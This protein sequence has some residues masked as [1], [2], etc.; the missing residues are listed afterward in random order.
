[1]ELLLSEFSDVNIYLRG[2]KLKFVLSRAESGAG[3][4]FCLF[5]LILGRNC[6]AQRGKV[7]FWPHNF[8]L[9]IFSQFCIFGP[10]RVKN[11]K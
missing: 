8:D 7:K 4:R 2:E 3:I 5:S 9:V 10:S 11:G 6:D 1:M